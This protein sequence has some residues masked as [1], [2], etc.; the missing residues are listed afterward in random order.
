MAFCTK[1]GEKMAKGSVFC[2]KCG[3]NLGEKAQ[4]Q[5]SAVQEAAPATEM[6]SKEK[7]DRHS[8][9]STWAYIG[10]SVLF[11]LPV[12]GFVFGVI[13]ACSS[14]VNLNLRN[15]SRAYLILLAIGLGLFIIFV[16]IMAAAI[17][18][19]VGAA[20]GSVD[21]AEIF[22]KLSTMSIQFE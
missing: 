5:Q 17:A 16:S 6:I 4:E 10:V 1:C 8:V 22:D 18:V 3:K 12:I 20:A 11:A 13:W 2:T 15:L 19:F 9:L 21:W 14:T 7:D